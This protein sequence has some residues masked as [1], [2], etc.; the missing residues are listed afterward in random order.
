MKRFHMWLRELSL[1]QQLLTILLLFLSIFAGFIFWFIAPSIEEFSESE[2]YILLHN[3]QTTIIPYLD[4]IE[5]ESISQLSSDDASPTMQIVYDPS[6]DD[7]EQ[8]TSEAVPDDLLDAIR[9]KAQN[10]NKGTS[11]YSA[12]VEKLSADGHTITE[13]YLYAMTLLNDGRYL[14]SIMPNAYRAQFSHSLI[15][16]VVMINVVFVF[17][18]LI[19]LIA[20]CGSLIFP[21][22]QIK[23]YI[24]KIKNDKPAELNIHRND[25]IGEVA[26]AL[27]D[28]E[29]ELSKQNRQKQEMI[30]NIS[31]DLKTPI[32]TIKSYSEAIKDGIYPYDTLE[33]SVDVIIEHADRLEKKVKSLIVLNKM[34][35]L[36]DTVK[37]GDNLEMKKVIDEVL[38]SLKVIRPEVS[39]QVDADETVKFHGEEEPW[40]IVV[41]NLIDNAL[42]Y[43]KSEVKVSLKRDEL[44]VINDGRP[45]DA[46]VID[47]LFH[48]YEKGSDG[49]FGLGLSIVYRVCH[50][51]G[52]QVS[53]ENLTDGVC[54][55]ITR[56]EIKKK[57]GT[58][59]GKSS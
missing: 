47:S 58:K 36:I 12:D 49:Q 39:F 34:D 43:A 18:L 57:R 9:A 55:R 7:F 17:V 22:N 38:L 52:Y 53:A 3:S 19:L 35:Y 23:Q 30:Q 42:R 33:K 20:W 6:T 4:D 37:D 51:Y 45:I 50:T 46:D 16:N 59:A 21:L 48:P 14:I 5:E 54:F 11:D 1:T 2:M 41:E 56:D 13:R 27:Q 10:G 44:C 29:S 24:T 15:N 28:M 31:H 40:R 26:D 8:L 32:A 25:E